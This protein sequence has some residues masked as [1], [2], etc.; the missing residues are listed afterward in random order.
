M[1]RSPTT[2]AERIAEA[3]GGNPLF[4]SEMLAMTVGDTDVEVPPTLKALLAA[5]LDQLDPAERKVLEYG[6]VEGEIFH[7]GSVHALAPEEAQVTTRLAGLVRRELIRP[8]RAQLSGDDGY[9]FRHLLIRDAAYNALPKSVRADLHARFA[10]WIDVR[11]EG[12]VEL[13][14]ILGYHLEQAARYLTELGKPDATLARDAGR[15]LAA[16]GLRAR[17][18]DD[19]RSARS[20]LARSIALDDRPD[21]HVLVHFAAVDESRTAELLLDEAAKRAE[22]AGDEPDAALARAIVAAMRAQ[23][24]EVSTDEQERLALA[25][26]PLLEAIEDHDGL[27]EIWFSL[28]YSLYNTRCRYDQMEY[29]AEEAVRHAALAGRPQSTSGSLMI[30]LQF[31]S[32]PVPEALERVD[33]LAALYTHP[34]ITLGRAVLLAMNGEI[35]AARTLAAVGEERFRELSDSAF[36]ILVRAEI[37]ELAGN[38]EASSELLRVFCDR[39]AGR[40]QT[41]ML[42]TYAPLRGRALCALG[43]HDEAEELA[44]QGRDLGD[45]DDPITQSLW[46]RVSALVLAHHGDV[47]A[48]QRLAN[49]AVAHAQKTDS[50][51]VQADALT[52]LAEVLRVAGNGKEAVAAL[53]DALDLYEQ[54]QIVPLVRRTRERLAELQSSEV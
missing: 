12:L 39:L 15:R 28:A 20:L 21:V 40:G 19:V 1:I 53:R 23:R 18:R 37:E 34:G 4:I 32:R 52:D 5:R 54:K 6:S 17:S 11:G 33:A 27:T 24:V 7:R 29:A 26:L 30:P 2:C 31:G 46:R 16:A 47:D 43:R 49:E 13:D 42:A 8:D 3:A 51:Q 50:L 25:A 35:D 38:L 45:E 14:E 48:A 22:L 10:A 36:P 41:A 44:T 9:R